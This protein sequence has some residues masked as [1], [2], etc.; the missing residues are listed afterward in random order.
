MPTNKRK[1]SSHDDQFIKD[2]VS[3]DHSVPSAPKD[4]WQKIAR[5]IVSE[6]KESSW[7]WKTGPIFIATMAVLLIFLLPNQNNN[8]ILKLTNNEVEEIARYL[9]DT[10]LPHEDEQVGFIA[11]DSL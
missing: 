7:F 5:T 8:N 2:L 9:I 11:F 4:E 10:S 3:N 1:T 6:K